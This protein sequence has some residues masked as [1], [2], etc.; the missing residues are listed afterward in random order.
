MQALLQKT[1]ILDSWELF[2]L[3]LIKGLEDSYRDDTFFYREPQY[4][5][6]DYPFVT[7]NKHRMIEISTVHIFKQL[8]N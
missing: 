5:R 4:A 8:M 7:F 1:I 2:S 3:T 6:H